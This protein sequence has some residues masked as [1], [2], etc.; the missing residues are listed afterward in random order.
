MGLKRFTDLP[1]ITLVSAAFF[2]NF[3][4]EMVQ[5]PL[6]DDIHRKTYTEI[7]VSRLHCTL[8]DVIILLGAYWIVAWVVRD[9]YWVVNLRVRHVC[10][11]TFLGL[12]YTILSEWVNVDIRS[13]W[14]YGATMPRVPF[15]GTGLAPFLQ[16][17]LLPPLIAGVT[18]RFLMR[19]SLSH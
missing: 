6:Y 5:S 2:I 9:R 13:A 10:G 7:L 12:G 16:W 14:G 11:F 3:F 8:G 19:K 1:E 15:V 4:W 18:R 17:L